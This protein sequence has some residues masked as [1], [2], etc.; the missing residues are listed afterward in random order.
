MGVVLY[1]RSVVVLAVLAALTGCS[2]A[3][4]QRPAVD[5]SAV[6]TKVNLPG[7][8]QACTSGVPTDRCSAAKIDARAAVKD[9]SQQLRQMGLEPNPVVCDKPTQKTPENCY[10][11]VL[12]EGPH[13]IS[14]F[15]FPHVLPT[16]PLTFDGVDTR[17]TVS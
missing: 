6:A 2:Q 11:Q 7:S 5:A 8:E 10:V 14:F 3:P 16:P 12:V 1:R 13:A 15:A 9:V 4:T 17:L